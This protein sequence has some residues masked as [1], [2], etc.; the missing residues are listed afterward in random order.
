[1][2]TLLLIPL[3]ILC[4]SSAWANELE[5]FE[6]LF[7]ELLKQY[8]S[9]PKMIH[10]IQT[11][12][13]DFKS[14]AED[15]KAQDSLF[16]RTL[17]A[18]ERTDLSV[19][20]TADEK[21]AF[22]INAYNLGA[23]KLVVESYPIRSIRDQKVSKGGYPWSKPLVGVSGRRLS[24][25]GIE[26]DKLLKY[27]KDPRLVF[28]VNCATI[29]CPDLPPVPFRAE[30]LDSQLDALMKDFLSNPTKGLQI[31]R[32]T[33]EIQ[34]S[35]IFEKHKDLIA[36]HFGGLPG[37][38]HRYLDDETCQ[39]F[40]EHGAHVTVSYLEHDWTLNDTDLEGS[41]AP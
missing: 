9:P 39:W 7:G 40:E 34:I 4:H 13:F 22:W 28:A 1:M 20:G 21:K 41:T 14:L 31:N 30:D 11:V 37:V 18:F 38:V 8:R 23:M 10:G 24:L 32:E 35:W 2:K 36:K 3:L 12:A 19:L 26:Q 17:E 27:F 25:E 33:G 29:S 6:T 16:A 15:S 5:R